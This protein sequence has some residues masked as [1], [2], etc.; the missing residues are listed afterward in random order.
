MVSC[1]MLLITVQRF[2]HYLIHIPYPLL[3]IMDSS[4]IRNLVLLCERE[5]ER[6]REERKRRRESGRH[7][8]RMSG[9]KRERKGVEEGERNYGS[10]VTSHDTT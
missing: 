8:E 3:C 10:V 4:G 2:K 1:S 7:G 5:R 9:R 6:E